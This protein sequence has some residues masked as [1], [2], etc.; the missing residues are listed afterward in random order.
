MAILMNIEL[1]FD[2]SGARIFS[3][4]FG[5]LDAL[6]FFIVYL[7]ILHQSFK[8]EFKSIQYFNLQFLQSHSPHNRL[9]FEY[10]KAQI[11]LEQYQSCALLDVF[12]LV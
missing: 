8:I 11:R 7:S 12:F 5:E 3:G 6:F 2:A 10:S 9:A 4:V 1:G